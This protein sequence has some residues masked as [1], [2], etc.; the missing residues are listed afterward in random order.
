MTTEDKE[1]TLAGFKAWK[2]K[3][4][5]RMVELYKGD[6]DRAIKRVAFLGDD[7]W[8]EFYT[9]GESA[10]AAAEEDWLHHGGSTY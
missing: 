7:V 9:D 10:E 6:R 1:T 5:A 4:L 2:S 3:L 8:F